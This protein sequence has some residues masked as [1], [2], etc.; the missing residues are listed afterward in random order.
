MLKEGHN[1]FWGS[2]NM[3]AVLAKLKEIAKNKFSPLE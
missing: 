2:F 3:G 1:T